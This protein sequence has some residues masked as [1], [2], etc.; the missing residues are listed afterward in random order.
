MRPSK[1]CFVT[2]V[3]LLHA[4]VALAE[5][6]PSKPTAATP[7]GSGAAAELER[8]S[9]SLSAWQ[10]AK[11]AC[12]GDYSYSVRFTS[13]FGFGHETTV[14]VRGNRIVHRSFTRFGRPEP[15][16]P[17]QA[18][19][20]EWVESGEEVGSHE[21]VGAA[22]A[23]TLDELYAIARQVLERKLDDRQVRSLVIDDR[24]LLQACFIRDAGIADDAPQHGVP[25]L[26]LH[27]GAK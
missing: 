5:D 18:P 27:L 13:A 7:T 17:P 16:Q 6:L 15:G 21:E 2:G 12:G 11:D 3:I 26:Q 24:G 22:Q 19:R 14:T 4:V 8:L 20:P 25:Y 23:R 9:K 1:S 10:Q